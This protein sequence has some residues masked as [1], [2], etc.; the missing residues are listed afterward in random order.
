MPRCCF[1][2]HEETRVCNRRACYAIID[3]GNEIAF[4]EEHF[5]GLPRE[6]AV[7]LR[8]QRPGFTSRALHR[9]LM[10]LRATF[11]IGG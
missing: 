4:C 6:R 1:Y 8:I 3:C 2:I 11:K 7:R 5:H 10:L 9:I